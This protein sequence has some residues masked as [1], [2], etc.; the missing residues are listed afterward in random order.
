MW[1]FVIGVIIVILAALFVTEAKTRLF[2]W[3]LWY[4]IKSKDKK[5]RLPDDCGVDYTSSPC[6]RIV[7][8]RHG[9]SEW[10]LVFNKGFGPS[11]PGR[12]LQ[13]IMREVLLFFHVD[14]VFI[15][16]PLSELG[17]KQ[18]RDLGEFLSSNATSGPKDPSSSVK[19]L[20]KDDIVAV[21]NGVVGSSVIVTSVLRRAISTTVV[22]LGKRLRKAD[23]QVHVMT[24]L[25]EISRNVDTLAITPAQTKPVLSLYEKDHHQKHSTSADLQYQTQT[26][27]HL[28]T[29]NKTLKQLGMHRHHEFIEWAFQEHAD[30]IVVGG[31][32]LW[33]REFFKSFMPKSAVHDAK[34][35]KIVNCGVVAFDL[36]KSKDQKGVYRIDP[37]SI[38]EIYGGFE[39]KKKDK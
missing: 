2:G 34:K 36:Y 38:K 15:D 24:S 16:S 30:W 10:N 22:C 11:F 35:Y 28:N 39:M 6:K 37:E 7:F 25:Q 14:S 33:F 31:H 8:I 17:V 4:M 19:T 26:T 20:E 21:I 9:E 23:E 27:A 5:L 1:D 18:A 13:A 32:S 3:G 12:L 29:G